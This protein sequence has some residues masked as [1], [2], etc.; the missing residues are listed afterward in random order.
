[1]ILRGS[2]FR[3][4][5]ILFVALVSGALLVS[6]L[7]ETYFSYRENRDALVALEQEKALGAAATIA[8]FV[9]AVEQQIGW[10]TQP[11]IVA[12][13]AAMEQRRS[14]YF[15]LLRQVLAVTEVSYI[16]PHG[17]EQLRV[18]RLAMDVVGSKTD[19]SQDPRFLQPKAGRAYFSPVYFRKES[20]PYMTIA[21]AGSGKES[22]VTA[23]EVNLKFI[24]D[25]VSQIRVGREGRAYVVDARGALIAHPDISLVLKKT[26]LSG[27]AQVRE[28]LR[29]GKT[30][31]ARP[32]TAKD[33]EGHSVLAASA[34]VAPLG[35]SVLIEQP[36]A[37]VV[38]PLRASAL[39]TGGLALFG[40]ILAV[41]GSLILARRMSRPIQA[42]QEGAARIGAGDL[43]H[44]LEVTTGD[45]IEALAEQFNTMTAQLRESYANLEHK[46]E[47]R[48]RELTEALEQQTATSEILGVISSSPTDVQPVFEV[49][50]E[51]AVRLCGG[52]FGRV[53]RY[54]GDLIH[55]VARHG[56]SA[57]GAEELQRV[58][59]RPATED[60]IVGRVITTRQAAY[61]TD[62]DRA[63]G[64]PLLSRQM[65]EALGTRS[66]VTVPMLRAGE[67]IGAMT[68]G[69]A[70]PDGF[71][72]QQ[73]ALLQTFANQA[74]I[75]IEN[76]R[77]FK[78]LEARN[79]DLTETLEQQTAT[80]EILR[81]IS[82]SQTDVQPVFETIAENSLRLCDATFST[83]FRFDGELVHLEALRNTTPEGADAIRNA[84]PMPPSRGGA[85]ARC[86]LT[87]S[88]VHISD[89]REDPDYVLLGLAET[90]KFRS[91][92]SVPML[93][94][95]NPIG[96]ITVAAPRAVPFPDKQV[97]VLKTFADQ[98]VIAV[99]NTRLFNEIQ[100]KTHQLEVANRHKSEFL[101]N[102][103][104]ELRTPLNA[105][106]GFSEVLL[107]RMFGEVNP[108][109][110]EYLNDILS[111]G[112]HLL[113][114]INDILDLSKIEAGRMELESQPFDLPAA[115]DNALTLIRE[116]A[117]RHGLR[118][119][120]TVDPGLGEVKGEERKVKQ[121]LLNLLSNAVKFTPEGGKISLSASLNDGMAEISVAD[122]GVGIA[123]EDQEAIFEE[124]RQVGS[125][126]ARKREGTGLGLALAR[127]LVALHGGKLWV[128][129]EP[130][131]GSTFTFTL[132]VS[133]HG[134]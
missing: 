40:V 12:P 63:E 112:K 36:W 73:I 70:E 16:D 6:G 104:H 50:V 53:Y 124:F 81:V 98:A 62:I 75:A 108:K 83:V 132:P 44:R 126:Y 52:R 48:T 129:S 56:V 18:S 117:A 64:I 31:V 80:A 21:L 97:E 84:F 49:I 115:L 71:G 17:L 41:L 94:D 128:E 38:E 35:W 4:Y 10:T 3:K 1:M 79:S 90:N 51:R 123:P 101:A 96:A 20:E 86:I 99:E 26:D 134:G 32:L 127:R 29:V 65:I 102:M 131:K 118:L 103:S 74:V 77:L 95:G 110:E 66:Q 27:L 125:D 60:T 34:P 116:R 22:G 13:A 69:W 14:D 39:R 105:V 85:S 25:V 89:V 100:D 61:V 30:G 57:A 2:L 47:E 122:T 72:E 111:S 45:E 11:P 106:I 59:P 87:R 43:S 82:S 33:L 133:G 88:V 121:V 54:D 119:E 114:L 28:A 7:L 58:F 120:V 8:Q 78:E 68:I 92:L 23:A 93:R 42:L 37:E 113:S 109:Q 46:V 76:V 107:E 67:P 91:I 19:Y 24:W 15:R 130:G 55:V 9:K 5:A